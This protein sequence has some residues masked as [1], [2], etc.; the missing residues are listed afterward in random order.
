[1]AKQTTAARWLAEPAPQLEFRQSVLRG[2][3]GA[4]KSL[5]CKYF[6]DERGSALF[7]EI[8]RQPEYYPTT[9]ETGILERCAA[10][11][12]GVTGPGAELV[13]LGSGASLKT[14]IVLRALQRPARYVPVD[15]SAEYLQGAAAS[16]AGEFPDLDIRP[17]IADFTAPFRLPARVSGQPRLVFFPGSTIGNFH[18]RDAARFL[19][20]TCRELSADAL[21]IGVDL[22]K[23]RAV[24]DAAYNDA[25]GVTAAFN[26]NL[27]ERIN[28]EL[29]ANFDLGA[30]G[31]QAGYVERRGRIE[32]HLRSLRDQEVRVAGRKIHFAAGESIHTENSYKYSVDEFRELATRSGWQMTHSWLDDRALFA[33]YLLKPA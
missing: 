6:Y 7:D 19:G 30:F 14:R 23:D 4:R 15:I 11:I 5:E 10:G 2:L 3:A 26:L 21:L 1:M 12:A 16:L 33:V 13:E 17:V 20:K 9:I 27:L 18:P 8:C 28:R 32:M 29:D 25:A 31:H 22:K 24:L